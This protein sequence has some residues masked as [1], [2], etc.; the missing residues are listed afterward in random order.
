ML[1]LLAARVF[2]EPLMM[3]QGKAEA[4]LQAVGGRFC[5]GGFV[6]AH[7]PAP[8]EHVAFESGRPSAGRLGDNLGRTYDRESRAPYDVVDGVAVIGIEG[9]LVHKGA[10]VGMSSGRT[11][12]QGLQAQVVRARR[13][14][15]VRGAVLEVDSFGGEVAGAFETADMIHALSQAKPT[16]AILTDFALSA[17]YLLASAARQVV[18]PEHGR[19]GSIGVITLH[20]DFSKKLA[21]DGVTVTVL[22]AGAHKGEGNPYGPLPDEVA[23][24]ITQGLEVARQSFAA[25][26][27]RYRGGRFPARAA[28]ATEALD[29]RGTDAV[30]LGLADAVGNP[31]EAFNAFLSAVNR[32]RLR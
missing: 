6:F 10:Y 11:S 1:D 31:N 13:D 25:H 32:D 28:L 19:A 12:Y 26:V 14:P 3:H 27:G 17:G 5:E 8:V 24:R 29:Y 7:A 9:T 23:Q 18:M 15:N 21:K 30:R 2:N 16:I 20:A 22:S 4:I